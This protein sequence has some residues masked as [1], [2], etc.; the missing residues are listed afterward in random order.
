[1]ARRPSVPPLPLDRA[2]ESLLWAS[3]RRSRAAIR[4]GLV[5]VNGTIVEDPSRIVNPAR[6]EIDVAGEP[7]TKGASKTVTL[8]VHKPHD[9]RVEPTP[10]EI[11]LYDLLPEREGWSAPCGTLTSDQ[12]GLVLLTSDPA[13]ADVEASPWHGLSADL[14]VV[15]GVTTR[16]RLGPFS[17]D[18]LESGSWQRL[19]GDAV[20][21][22]D[23][24]I[25]AGIDDRTPLDQVWEEIA[26][27]AREHED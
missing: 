21:A 9:V 18:D 16:T 1:M 8:I 14:D 22:L 6:D 23:A 5:V 13:H 25:S 4:E 7:L 19:T 2:L 3:V 12:A 20:G 17:L 10:D 15:N 26:R 27:A 24:M 11:D